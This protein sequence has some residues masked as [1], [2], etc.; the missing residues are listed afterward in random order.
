MT[1]IATLQRFDTLY[2]TRAIPSIGSWVQIDPPLTTMLN[3]FNTLGPQSIELFLFDSAG[4]RVGE[5]FA[6]TIGTHQLLRVDLAT[7]L[8]DASA[9]EGCVW[10]WSR[11]ETDEGSLG[12]QA[13][14]LEFIDRDRPPGHVLG[15]VHLIFDFLDTLGIAPWL[16]LVS[17]RVIVGRTPEGAPAFRNYLGL[18]HIPFNGTSLG[19]AD[20]ELTVSNQRGEQR[21]AEPFHLP[22]LGS[23]F[24]DLESVFGDLTSFLMGD[25]ENRGY[26]VV[27]V[28]EANGALAGMAG[29][30]KV[31]DAVSG[32]MLVGHLNDRNFARPAMK[33][34]E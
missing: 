32:E 30:I 8:P 18:A 17:P 23:W 6:R 9:F 5:P 33:D 24:G 22:V 25:D 3:A 16:D 12:L 28:R 27:N 26:G 1:D 4:E 11:G 19:G 29:M 10:V 20:I 31:V 15:S 13:I 14:D 34:P 2:R 7:L 21:R